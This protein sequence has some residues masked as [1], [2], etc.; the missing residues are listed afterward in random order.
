MTPLDATTESC[1]RI[2]RQQ[3][4]ACDQVLFYSQS[5]PHVCIKLW[6]A[7]AATAFQAGVM[8]APAVLSISECGPRLI[9]AFPRP[10]LRLRKFK[11]RQPVNHG[12]TEYHL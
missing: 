9:K 12:D 5:A 3:V 11:T 7:K 4:P 10:R 1:F 2:P 6:F 8:L